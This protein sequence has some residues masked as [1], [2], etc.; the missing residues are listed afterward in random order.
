MGI[1]PDNML[2]KSSPLEMTMEGVA[3]KFDYF[4]QQIHLLHLQTSSYAEHKALQVWDSMP[5]QKDEFLEKLMGYEGRKLRSYKTPPIT[6]Y[7]LGMPSR[8]LTDLKEFAEQLESYA[9]IKNYSDIENLAQS[10]SGSAS[11][12]LYLLTLS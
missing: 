1:F 11:Q 2:D 8:I 12:T 9:R 6:D 4:F 3:S 7:S 10:L 5:N